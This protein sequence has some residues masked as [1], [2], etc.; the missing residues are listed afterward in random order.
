MIITPHSSYWYQGVIL[1]AAW[2]GQEAWAAG[3]MLLPVTCCRRSSQMAYLVSPAGCCF[4]FKDQTCPA[5]AT[6]HTGVA[7]VVSREILVRCAQAQALADVR[8]H[9]CSQQQHYRL[10]RQLHVPKAASHH[11][12]QSGREARPGSMLEA[13]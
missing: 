13:G 10:V 3:D 6:Q 4:D 1:E 11:V 2:A 8:H 12:K 7:M 5:T 9:S